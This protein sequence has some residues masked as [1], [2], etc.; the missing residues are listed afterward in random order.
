MMS[1]LV[2]ALVA[3][4]RAKAGVTDGERDDFKL[5]DGFLDTFA[6][7]HRDEQPPM[8]MV[9]CPDALR[10]RLAADHPGIVVSER[11]CWET[12]G[13]A[14]ADVPID[15]SIPVATLLELIDE[16]HTLLHEGLDD[17]KRFL[18]ELIARDAAPAEALSDLIEHH[19]L[20]SRR[21]EIESLARP[22]FAIVTSAAGDDEPPVGSTRIGGRPDLD[23]STEWPRH[24]DGRPMTF[25]AQI[26]LDELPEGADRGPLPPRGLLS[27]FSAWG[28]QDEDGADP[29]PPDGE[30]TPEW[31]CI[32][33]FRDPS[34]LRRRSTPDGVNDFPAAPGV[35]VPIVSLPQDPEEPDVEALGWDEATWDAFS[36]LLCSY[37]FL[38]AR[39]VGR[40]L[41]NQLLGYASFIQGFDPAAGE[42]RRLLFQLGSDDEA[43]MCWGDGGCLYFF[44]DP[45]ARA[46]GDFS[47]VE[48]AYQCN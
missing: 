42:G 36:G 44:A 1:G 22:A 34:G 30:P 31:T 33:H 21:G 46:R 29:L 9:R 20:E 11:M 15:G 13:W 37:D 45:E 5:L 43:A 4:C 24:E 2:E 25:L 47:R 41:H 40:P 17:S 26:N 38:Q 48:S 3:R 6:R 23:D 10:E 8:V 35:I 12:E 28:R 19:G 18:I 7:F 32:F 39:R 27:I 16:S 14:W